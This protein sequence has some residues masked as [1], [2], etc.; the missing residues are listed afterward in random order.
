MNNSSEEVAFNILGHCKQ[1]QVICRAA[2]LNPGTATRVA[3]SPVV[4]EMVI[5]RLLLYHDAATRVSDSPVVVEMEIAVD[6]ILMLKKCQTHNPE[7][8]LLKHPQNW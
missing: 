1:S 6:G 2:N 7:I 5:A 8:P 4:I 3:D